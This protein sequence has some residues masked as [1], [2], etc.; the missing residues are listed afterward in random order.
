MHVK[1]HAKC[2]GCFYVA[3]PRIY[4]VANIWDDGVILRMCRVTRLCFLPAA[5]GTQQCVRYCAMLELTFS[6]SQDHTHTG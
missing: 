5:M 3:S 4:A 6:L 2:A 1:S